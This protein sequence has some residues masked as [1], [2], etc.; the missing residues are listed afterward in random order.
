MVS[1]KKTDSF[2]TIYDTN[3]IREEAHELAMYR[4]AYCEIAERNRKSSRTTPSLKEDTVA[5][6]I[7]PR[8]LR[9]RLLGTEMLGIRG[10][11]KSRTEQ[12]K[13]LVDIPPDTF[14][15]G[16]ERLSKDPTAKK[17]TD[18][19]TMELQRHM[20]YWNSQ[21][22]KKGGDY[23]RHRSSNKN[24]QAPQLPAQNL[25]DGGIVDALSNTTSS[26]D[27]FAPQQDRQ[28]DFSFDE[29]L[30]YDQQ[31]ESH[32]AQDMTSGL[33]DSSVACNETY[34]PEIRN[35]DPRSAESGRARRPRNPRF[36]GN[37]IDYRSGTTSSQ[38]SDALRRRSSKITDSPVAPDMTY[39]PHVPARFP[40]F[41]PPQGASE[42]TEH[43]VGWPQPERQPEPEHDAYPD[44][45]PYYADAWQDEQNTAATLSQY[46]VEPSSEPIQ[47]DSN[48]TESYAS[49]NKRID[50]Q[51]RY[52]EYPE[53]PFE[54]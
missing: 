29:W 52:Q 33:T 12:E 25:Y 37:I 46:L 5:V 38:N 36:G 43:A 35:H 47:H 13:T 7:H 8:D 32:A 20:D 45:S 31:D 40:S 11:P 34:T 1:F 15:A 18:S 22:R 16:L 10:G 44:P 21:T 54:E 50:P 17:L 39:A 3:P 48:D 24:I 23:Y 27:S 14:R 30:V 28:N 6:N 49:W 42:L 41:D 2:R 53:H 26:Q 19:E 4:I 9:K 51:L